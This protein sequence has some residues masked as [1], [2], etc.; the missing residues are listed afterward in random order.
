MSDLDFVICSTSLLALIDEESLGYGVKPVSETR[1]IRRKDYGAVLPL[2]S[3][4]LDIEGAEA[5]FFVAGTLISPKHFRC[6]AIEAS[7]KTDVALLKQL[8]TDRS[9]C[10]GVFCLIT[11]ADSNAE[12][13]T[14]ELGQFPLFIYHKGNDWIVAS[15]PWTIVNL[16]K[17]KNI[18]IERDYEGVAAAMIYGTTFG[19]TTGFTDISLALGNRVQI[20]ANSKIKI[21]SDGYLQELF[22]PVNYEQYLNET[23]PILAQGMGTAIHTLTGASYNSV[24]DIT[25]GMD[26][27]LVASMCIAA[28]CMSDLGIYSLGKKPRPDR[29]IADYLIEKYNWTPGTL[30][31]SGNTEGMKK[32][33]EYYNRAM[34]R[35]LGMKLSEFPDLS[36]THIQRMAR[37]T[38][39]YGEFSRVFY[40]KYLGEPDNR[41]IESFITGSAASCFLHPDAI[42]NFGTRLAETLARYSDLGLV[43]AAKLNALYIENRSKV[44]FGIAAHAADRSRLGIHPLNSSRILRLGNALP[45]RE[46]A[47]NKLCFDL[48]CKLAGQEFA[49]EPMAGKFWKGSLVSKLITDERIEKSIVTTKTKLNSKDALIKTVATSFARNTPSR[50]NPTFSKQMAAL[51]KPYFWGMIPD[52][53]AVIKDEMRKIPKDHPIYS[54]IDRAR[55]ESLSEQPPESFNMNSSATTALCLAALFVWVGKTEKVSMIQ[56]TV[57]AK[58]YIQK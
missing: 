15:D 34:F 33:Q 41:I 50:A 49:L 12:L 11:L 19:S 52:S 29:M 1:V 51:G 46:H 9:T 23:V 3:K 45:E 57:D 14:D 58:Q 40:E 5:T 36:D 35:S 48:I 42:H 54:Y 22:T 2:S 37:I 21:N 30:V 43:G 16:L 20:D 28:G 53:L 4:S 25:G 10:S 31:V 38:G 6:H 13:L 7:A 17:K 24:I 55:V 56:N 18:S 44:H 39:Y 8:K 26:T 27:R 32:Y 47:N